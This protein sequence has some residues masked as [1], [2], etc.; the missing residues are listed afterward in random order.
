MGLILLALIFI[1]VIEVLR[2]S[3]RGT[4]Q[5]V[6]LTKAFQAARAAV[7]AAEA[8][9]F[10]ELTDDR[11]R[12]AI[13]SL[14]LPPGV[15]RPRADPVKTLPAGPGGGTAQLDVKVVTVRVPWQKAEG[16]E[17]RGEVVLHGLVLRSR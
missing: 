5:S 8:C 13:D 6:H 7:D 3:V 14:E 10:V 4:A 15:E 1:P 16:K 2:N 12:T 11:L 9:T 17:E